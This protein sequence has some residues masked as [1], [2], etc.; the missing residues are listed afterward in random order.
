MSRS[1]YSLVFYLWRCLRYNCRVW[2]PQSREGELT[3]SLNLSRIQTYDK[4]L[5]DYSGFLYT[6]TR[7]NNSSGPMIDKVGRR[8]KRKLEETKLTISLIRTMSI[9]KKISKNTLKLEHRDCCLKGSC[10]VWQNWVGPT[11]TFGFY[12][13]SAPSI[14]NNLL[15]L[16]LLLV[17]FF[18][19]FCKCGIVFILT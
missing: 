3:N 9:S 14:N 13:V 2:R 16:F 11:A 5:F 1:I 7:P 17:L 4:I 19:F 8:R 10:A 18:P 12:S 6:R 15:L